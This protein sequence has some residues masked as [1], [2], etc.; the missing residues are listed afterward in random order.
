MQPTSHCCTELNKT[1]VFPVSIVKSSCLSAV[2]LLPS[3]GV[4]YDTTSKVFE[5]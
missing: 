2:S 5:T 1:Q 4:C 3:Y